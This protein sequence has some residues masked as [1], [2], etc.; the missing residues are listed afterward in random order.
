MIKENKRFLILLLVLAVVVGGLYFV[1]NMFTIKVKGYLA[2]ITV[3]DSGDMQVEETLTMKYPGGYSVIY[4]DIVYDKG[5]TAG[6]FDKASLDEG[7]LE[8][9]V[10][11]KSG[12]PMTLASNVNCID[13]DYWIGYSFLNDRDERGDRITC[14][15]DLNTTFC[16]AV[17]IYVKAG[18]QEKMTFKFKYTILGAVTVFDDVAQL[19]WKLIEYFDNKVKGGKVNITLPASIYPLEDFYLFGHGLYS[20]VIDEITVSNKMSMTFDMKKE[21]FME[22]RLLMPVGLFPNI[23]P[24]NMVNEMRKA[25]ILEEEVQM[26]AGAKKLAIAALVQLY[27]FVAMVL[28]MAYVFYHV[29]KKY[30]KELKPQFDGDYFRELPKDYSPAEMSYLYYFKK[31][32]DEDVTA[33]ILDL[34]R[35]K[36]L[37]L[38]ASGEELTGKKP[39]FKL[40]LNENSTEELKSHEALIIKWFIKEVGDGNQVGLKQLEAYPKKNFA[41]AEL[42]K[43]YGNDFKTL[44]KREG[45]KHNFFDEEMEKKKSKAKGFMLIPLLWIVINFLV[46]SSANLTPNYIFFI[47]A[48]ALIIL[49][50]VYITVIKKRSVEGNEDFA[51][52]KAFRKFLTDFGNMKDYPMPGVIV[53]E[54]YL[55]YATSLKI[56]DQVMKQLE[57]KLPSDQVQSSNSTFMSFGYGYYGFRMGMAF[58]SITRSVS[59]ARSNSVSTIAAH[60]AAQ[61]G[62]RFGGGGGFS[63][64]SS[65]G[66]GGGGFR[67]R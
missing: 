33:T 25:S 59:T 50:L 11:D 43:K 27:S 44:A 14:S 21:D 62:G 64:G 3:S 9:S 4:R 56:A 35:R 16:E 34:V 52:W 17:F 10:W 30:D 5:P 39:N 40:I 55:V 48:V 26:A 38:D 66:G 53:W 67:S 57:V 31:I 47:A 1:G 58:S 28:V 22:F 8:V 54:H 37:V 6:G 42:F 65:F 51:K 15:P 20:G 49:L 2:D 13:G 36:V 60:H 46:T 45:K 61:G 23:A 24:A 29:Y 41:Q 7:S 19:N 18:M 63:G 32:N 12:T